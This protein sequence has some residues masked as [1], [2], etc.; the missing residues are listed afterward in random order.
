M[1]SLTSQSKLKFLADENVDF[2][3][4][5]T[6]KQQGM[7]IILKPKGSSDEKIAEFSK[8]EERILI[9]NDEDFTKFSKESVFSVAWLRIPQRK[10]ESL[11]SSFSRMLK[12]KTKPSDFEGFLIA[13]KEDNFETSAL[14]TEYKLKK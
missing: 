4:V 11:I 1:S 9:T 5:K 2:R 6:L 10:I 14:S 3:L 7:D 8:S 13:L 12:E